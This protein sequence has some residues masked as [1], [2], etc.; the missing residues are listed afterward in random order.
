MRK[1]LALVLLLPIVGCN[2][3]VDV[4]PTSIPPKNFKYHIDTSK[5]MHLFGIGGVAHA[6]PVEGQ[7][8][9]ARHVSA[10]TLPTGQTYGL[11]FSWSNNGDYGEAVHYQAATARDLSKL[12]LM[13]GQT[14][15][16]NKSSK[17]PQA[18]EYVYWVE[19]N[20]RD[21]DKAFVPRTRRAKVMHTI[22]NHV[23][24]DELPV[25]GASGGCIFNA[26]NEV[27]GILVWG[28]ETGYNDGVGVGVLITRGI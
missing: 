20:L 15:Y 14:S 3:T 10:R 26:E 23:V 25:K 24:F 19:Y 13:S 5:V 16:Y 22:A 6:C 2:K 8:L 17:D 4:S 18:G 1:L 12:R 28:V 27:I 7:I 9:T 21:K 11:A